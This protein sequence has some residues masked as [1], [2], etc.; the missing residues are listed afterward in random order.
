M[1]KGHLSV[2]VDDDTRAVLEAIQRQRGP[3]TTLA[4]IVRDALRRYAAEWLAEQ[5]GPPDP[6]RA[7]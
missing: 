1:P 2:R 7:R 3:D 4:D 5:A 6:G